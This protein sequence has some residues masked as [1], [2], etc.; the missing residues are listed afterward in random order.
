MQFVVSGGRLDQQPTGCIVVGMYEDGKLSPS[1]IELDA[2]R[3]QFINDA[4][5]RGDF[6]GE[7]GGT[8]LLNGVPNAVAERVLLG[9]L[10]AEREFVESSY[11]AALRAS[12]KTL[13]TTGATE[14]TLCVSEL[15][16]DGR[17]SGWKVEQA[18]QQK[19]SSVT[20][21]MGLPAGLKLPF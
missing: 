21:S 8:L 15:S 9:G 11:H 3:G 13:L 17:N 10:G 18:V 12:M 2:A 7:L 6:E 14:A 19:M 20:G 5:T 4:W 1:A 16:V